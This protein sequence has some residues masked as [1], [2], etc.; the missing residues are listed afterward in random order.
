MQDGDGG[1][2]PKVLKRAS[3]KFLTSTPSVDHHPELSQTSPVALQM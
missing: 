2:H 3:E 1:E